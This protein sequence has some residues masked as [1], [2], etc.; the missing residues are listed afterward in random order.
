MSRTG[1]FSLGVVGAALLLPSIA[2]TGTADQALPMLAAGLAL[3][4]VG[5]HRLRCPAALAPAAIGLLLVA[6]RAA[7]LPLPETAGTLPDGAG[8]W[9]GRVESV[10]APRQGRQRATAVLETE[11]PVRVA[12][13]APRYPP[14]GPA[15][16]VTVSGTP[17]PPPD[18][19]YG[20]Y[21]RRSGVDAT[22]RSRTLEVRTD[23]GDPVRA[24]EGLRRAGGDALA[25]ALPEPEAGLAAGILIGLRDRVDRA[26]AA[27][28]T[29]AGVSHVVAISGWNIAI[30]ALLVDRLLVAAPRRRRRM[31][32]LGAIALYTVL[33]GASPSVLRAAA[34]ASAVTLARESGRAG[35]ARDALALAVAG[36]ILLDPE[37]VADPGFQLSA[38]ATAGLIAWAT[39]I[40]AWLRAR[41]DGRL[42][43]WLCIGLGVSLAAQIA[44]L[45]VV[46][47][48]F[49]RLAALSPLLNLAVVPLVPLAM[50]GGTLALAVG[51]AALAGIAPAGVVA[52]LAIPGWLPLAAL[53]AVVRTGASLPLASV[54]LEPPANLVA[55][56]VIPAALLARRVLPLLR[57]RSPGRS[58]RRGA[59]GSGRTSAPPWRERLR[60]P[61][62]RAALGVL[63]LAVATTGLAVAH[64]PDGRFRIVALDVG[65]GD[66]ILVEG[67]RGSRL[68]VDG[69]PDPDRLVGALDARL[70]PWDRRLDV[71]ILSH[72]HEDHVA[73]LPLLLERYRVGRAF[74]PGMRGAGPGYAAWSLAL[75]MHGVPRGRLATGDALMVDGVRFTVL[76]PDR[77]AVP[78]E[79]PD[80]GTGVNNVSVVLLGQIGRQHVL[81]TGD[82]EEEI[83]PVLLERGLPRTEVLKVAHHGSRTSSTQPMI[84]A[85]RPRVALVSVGTGNTYGHPSPATLGRLEAAGARVGRTDLDG[86]VEV[87]LDGRTVEVATERRR[88][89]APPR[90]SP[91]AVRHAR[92]EGPL[93]YD[94]THVR[95]RPDRGGTSP[96]LPD[97]A[98]LAPAPFAWRR[99]GGGLARRADGGTRRDAPGRSASPGGSLAGGGRGA[100]ARHRQAVA[101]GASRAPPAARHCRRGM[102]RGA[103]AGPPGA[104]RRRSSGHPPRRRRVLG[105]LAERGEPGGDDRRLRRQAGRPAPGADGRQV[106]RLG[107]ALPV[108]GRACPG[109]RVVARDRVA[110]ARARRRAGVAGD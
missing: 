44:T 16:L 91:G 93:G 63:V 64:Q 35:N 95:A 62:P 41:A 85:L 25:L 96:R 6:L 42:P 58:G 28:F 99:G 30:V 87:S 23:P 3:V 98:S 77:D 1:W 108:R 79:P 88:G 82:L 9:Q 103:R 51:A 65:Q 38:L 22:L 20:A 84:D 11:P 49:G 73:G 101:S 104:R 34:M 56:G 106:R 15:D 46:L 109:G 8:P 78:A 92:H 86:S 45:P 54:E 59:P 48:S 47:L 19:D 29:Q 26:V 94:R 97:A 52:V 60:R 50:A 61:L 76:W 2:A 43:E 36:L 67:P 80:D 102:A 40:T 21:L 13:D 83:E 32:T 17:Q 89:S 14:I 27:T 24:V 81:L 12:L 110:R 72:P 90:A 33:T 53:V 31:V 107:A 5:S 37:V 57:A 74:E 70:P 4:A 39:P 68:L 69:G 71:V 7:A 75:A 55:A 10:S 100:A 18:D 66:A 105:A